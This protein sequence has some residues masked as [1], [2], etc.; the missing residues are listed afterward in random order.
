V[1]S[2]LRGAVLVLASLTVLGA[3]AVPSVG[4][5][6]LA[7]A[8]KPPVNTRYTGT[9]TAELMTKSRVNHGN[10]N[11]ITNDEN[12]S[13]SG[14]LASVRFA[15]H[16]LLGS[17]GEGQLKAS[18]TVSMVSA[19]QDGDRVT[20]CTGDSVSPATSAPPSLVPVMGKITFYA[21]NSL[22]APADCVNNQ[23]P[24]PWTEV[25][26]F[27]A[28]PISLDIPAAKVGAATIALPFSRVL[29]EGGCPPYTEVYS[30]YCTYSLKGTLTLKLVPD[31]DVFQAPTKARL[32]KAATRASVVAGCG[33]A[34]TATLTLRPLSGAGRATTRESVGAHK[35]KTVSLGLNK[36]LRKSV[37]R[38][39]GARLEVTYRGGGVTKTF[40]QK[41][42]L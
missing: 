39:G 30:E 7:K 5:S 19:T 31:I 25:W 28:I 20:T 32:T 41:V 36:K 16:R 34:C 2:L 12:V 21:F 17:F 23:D 13:L 27:Q 26:G 8:P 9:F 35:S 18:G 29:T 3:G 11:Y 38:S 4:S 10:G 1:R 40:K 24:E 37:L 33:S 6:A 42:R 14:T 15:D 22:S